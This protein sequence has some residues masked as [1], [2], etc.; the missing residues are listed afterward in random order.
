M[1]K[2]AEIVAEVAN[3][4][5]GDP[6][7]ALEI[8]RAALA[9]GADAVK[10]QFYTAEELLVRSHPR[11]EHFQKQSFDRAAWDSIIK[12][13]KADGARIYC[14]VF[15]LPAL[16]LAIDFDVAGYKIH[17]S[18]LSNDPLVAKAA[19]ASGRLLLA[20]GGSTAR[21]IAQAIA[22]V[23]R[24]APDK[25]VVLLHG[26]QSYPT[27]VEDTAL[28]RLEWLRQLAGQHEI[29]MSDHIAGDDPMSRMVPLLALSFGATMLEKH[30]TL[31][32]SA[33]GV[34]YYSSLEPSELA[35]FV[36]MTRAAESAIHGPIAVFSSAERGYRDTVKK[37]WVTAR[38]LPAG[39]VLQQSDLCMKR[40][41]AL[42][43]PQ[44]VAPAPLT[45]LLGR[46]LLQ[47]VG[48]EHPLRRSDTRHKVA[49]CIV[50]RLKSRRLPRKALLDIAGVPALSHLFERIKQARTPDLVIFC[51]SD[52]PEDDPLEALATA[53]GLPTFRGASDNVVARMQGALRGTDADL[54]IRVTGD[55]IMV[56]PDYLDA[57]VRH[58][59][60]VNAEYTDLKALPS[61]TEIEVFDRSVIDLIANHAAD[62]EGT[63]Y[64]T[65]YIVDNRD[66]FAIA[67]APVDPA[68]RH[69]WRLT[70]DT[71]EDLVVV[72]S[73][74]DAMAKQGKQL[75]YRLND[76]AS[77]IRGNPEVMQ[78]NAEVRQRQTPPQVD[79]RI[80][81]RS[82]LDGLRD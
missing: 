79:T 37:H 75:T 38:A 4:H 5:Q 44:P 43:E 18:D 68:H 63:E 13:L 58:H 67:S 21:E 1:S 54:V 53:A 66:Q 36:A 69:N 17:S 80:N 6:K 12:P 45:S 76:I 49:V 81:W 64:L 23:A 77:Y 48:A 46:P 65:T 10:F 35:E 31:D 16:Q 40:V 24:A 19:M 78:A 55:D 51:T 72:R 74:L 60:A 62:P 56:D 59:L 50:A 9:A 2:R 30:V 28:A 27:A 22:V 39:H 14:D 47:D 20:T 15:G 25:R 73:L 3:A 8:A 61:G 70:L 32:R 26:F 71:P 52:D 57:A 42:P 11:Y 82:Y 34:D 41:P 33:K 7:R 29:G